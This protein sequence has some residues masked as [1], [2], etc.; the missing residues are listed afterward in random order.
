MNPVIINCFL[1]GGGGTFISVPVPLFGVP[2]FMI[3][4]MG[5]TLTPLRP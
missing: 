1:P 2:L 4:F 5:M 3:L